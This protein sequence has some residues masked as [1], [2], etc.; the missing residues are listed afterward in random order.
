MVEPRE[1]EI[2]DLKEE[3]TKMESELE[4]FNKQNNQLDLINKEKDAKLDA[5]QKELKDERL[6]VIIIKYHN[7][8]KLI[9][10]YYI[11]FV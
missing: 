2:K 3:K 9:P 8:I 6:K 10:L 4:R 1:L 11:V 7:V 5:L